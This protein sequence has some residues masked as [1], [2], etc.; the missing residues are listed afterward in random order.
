MCHGSLNF[1]FS[2]PM[3]VWLVDFPQFWTFGANIE[4]YFISIK[5]I[6]IIV[7]FHIFTIAML[8]LHILL[9][10]LKSLFMT[11]KGNYALKCRPKKIWPLTTIFLLLRWHS[12]PILSERNWKT[13]AQKAHAFPLNKSFSNQPIQTTAEYL[14]QIKGKTCHWNFLNSHHF[15]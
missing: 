15:S 2:I 1:D 13:N 14:Y 10:S 12:T 11:A 4:N 5:S 8:S 6:S 3:F 9:L 7:N